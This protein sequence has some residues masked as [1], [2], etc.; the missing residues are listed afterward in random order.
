MLDNL[1]YRIA[2]AEFPNAAPFLETL[3]VGAIGTGFGGDAAFIFA[4]GSV[5]ARLMQAG[6]P[7]PIAITA[8]G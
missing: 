3:N 4:L 1:P 5:D 8:P 6:K 2:R 7:P